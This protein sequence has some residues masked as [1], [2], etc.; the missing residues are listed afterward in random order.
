MT[1]LR[2]TRP[3]TV[4][5]QTTVGTALSI[6][7]HANVR[8]LLVL[9]AEHAIC[10]LVAAR[11]LGGER[12][13]RVATE[14]R[15]P[16]DQVTVGHVMTGVDE[17]RPLGLAQVRTA[18]VR[19]VVRHLATSKRQHALVLEGSEEI[20]YVARGI[21]SATQI[22]RQ[23]GQEVAVDDGSVNSFAELERLIA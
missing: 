18:S 14:A 1:D 2:Q 4:A 22:G 8:L 10:G 7:I 5:P 12:P 3:V 21:L 15:I 13:L 9:D 20:G 16:Y 17:M 6:M 19:D 23:L 11:D